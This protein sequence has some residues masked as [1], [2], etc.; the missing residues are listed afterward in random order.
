MVQN[1]ITQIIISFISLILGI[2]TIIYG[3]RFLFDQTQGNIPT[4]LILILFS[5]ISLVACIF[6]SLRNARKYRKK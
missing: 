4:C 5:T 6:I 1:L 3:V 2:Y